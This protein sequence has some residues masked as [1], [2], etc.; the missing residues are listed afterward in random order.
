MYEYYLFL[1]SGIPKIKK[2]LF[3][4]LLNK[5]VSDKIEKVKLTSDALCELWA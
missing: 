5:T 2:Y 1:K 3:G 4:T